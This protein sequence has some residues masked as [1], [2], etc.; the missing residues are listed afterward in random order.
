MDHTTA[1][2]AHTDSID[3][4]SFMRCP[5]PESNRATPAF[6]LRGC[7]GNSRPGQRG[8][9]DSPSSGLPFLP[10]QGAFVVAE[11]WGLSCRS[12]VRRRFC[13]CSLRVDRFDR[14]SH[15]PAP[16][17]MPIS[18]SSQTQMQ[19][20]QQ[21]PPHAPAAQQDSPAAPRSL[22]HPRRRSSSAASFALMLTAAAA[23]AATLLLLA[24]PGATAFHPAHSSSGAA[25]I[26]HHRRGGPAAAGPT[27]LPFR[28]RA[29]EPSRCVRGVYVRVRKWPSP[30]SCPFRRDLID[31][32]TPPQP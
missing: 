13:S 16:Q 19:Q 24:L 30:V 10:I 26:T 29:I 31:A 17:N 27:P 5:M 11:L 28:L 6:V 8:V 4:H 12:C 22:L 18:P 7:K 14:P 25:R 15:T 32:G 23:T 9:V 21:Q 1:P 3:P 20:Q 2:Q